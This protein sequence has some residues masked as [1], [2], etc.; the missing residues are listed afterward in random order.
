LT[1]YVR[2]TLIDWSTKMIRRIERTIWSVLD[3]HMI[4]RISAASVVLVVG[5]LA[6]CDTMR[7]ADDDVALNGEELTKLTKLI[8]GNTFRGAWEGQQLTMVYYENGVVAGSQGLTG[9]DR[10][11]W[12]VDEDIY[13]HRWTRLFGSTRRCFKWWRRESDYLLQN[14]D[15]FRINNLTGT[16]EPGKPPGF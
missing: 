16:V 3:T 1:E 9:S 5:L 11:T 7:P 2:G 4:Q 10:G 13:C 15:S 8:S 6:G 12:T 14:V